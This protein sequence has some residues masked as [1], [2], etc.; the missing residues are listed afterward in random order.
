MKL[1]LELSGLEEALWVA[2]N[3]DLDQVFRGS[4]GIP[5]EERAVNCLLLGMNRMITA[6]ADLFSPETIAICT[7]VL[8][9]R[10]G[11]PQKR[12]V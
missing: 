11:K 7:R 10:K 9:S 12:L 6:Q 8:E 4:R 3:E 1:D 2:Y 5:L